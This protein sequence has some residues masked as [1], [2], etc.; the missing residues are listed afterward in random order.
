MRERESARATERREGGREGGREG[1]RKRGRKTLVTLGFH[2]LSARES[3]RERE[4][5]GGWVGGAHDVGH[6][7][8]PCVQRGAQ[9]HW[10]Q[11]HLRLV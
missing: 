1:E 5:V 11:P 3:E 2:L 7:G 10:Y 6:V 8:L 9:H 4:R